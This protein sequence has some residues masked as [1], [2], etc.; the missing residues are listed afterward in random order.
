MKLSGFYFI[1]EKKL[2]DKD[3]VESVRDAVCGGATVVQYREKDAGTRQMFHEAE[4]MRADCQGKALFLINDR[5]DVAL[6]VDADGVHLGQEDMSL[7]TAR[8]LLGDEKVIGVTVHDLGE[9]L[10][11]EAGGADYLGVSPI[12]ATLTKMD[13]GEPMGADLITEIRENTTLPL[14]AIGGINRDNV[15][16][17]LE[18]G[19]D[20]VC[21]VSATVK[22][23]I[24]DNVRFFAEKI[25]R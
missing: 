14:A 16:E 7:H 3:V 13:A 4:K 15:D 11:A 23:D 10:E 12:F 19:A 6:A 25:G 17:V 24:E 18:A 22:G 20:M 9:A 21:A 2:C 8:R 5:V 1:T